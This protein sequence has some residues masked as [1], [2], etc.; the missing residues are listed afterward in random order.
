MQNGPP[1]VYDTQNCDL[2]KIIHA[3]RAQEEVTFVPLIKITE[4]DVVGQ[5][6]QPHIT[7]LCCGKV[8]I[9]LVWRRPSFSKGRTAIPMS[10]TLSYNR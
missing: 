6:G 5:L 10:S 8:N 9:G 4:L 7:C 3:L 2:H 1:A